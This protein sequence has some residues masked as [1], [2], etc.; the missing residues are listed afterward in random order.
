MSIVTETKPGALTDLAKT[1]RDEARGLVIAYAKGEKIESDQVN[2]VLGLAGWSIEEFEQRVHTLRSRFQ[3]AADLER[4]DGMAPQIEAAQETAQEARAD[5]DRVFEQTQ[6]KL[7]EAEEARDAA[8]QKHSTLAGEAERLQRVAVRLLQE[9][10]DPR[11]EC[12]ARQLAQR[13]S[14]ANHSC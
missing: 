2:T 12:D 10:T 14:A 11:L 8:V 9:T 7:R 1:A 6:A 5:F 3:A 4:A 13:A